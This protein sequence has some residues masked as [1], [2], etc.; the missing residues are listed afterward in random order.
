MKLFRKFSSAVLL[1][2]GFLLGLMFHTAGASATLLFTYTSKDLLWKESYNQGSPEDTGNDIS[3]SFTLT[4]TAPY[5][6]WTQKKSTNFYM[7]NASITV[8]EN[9]ILNQIDIGSLSSGRVTLDQQGNVVG[10]N[11]IL[12]LKEFLAAD[13]SGL[14]KYLH[15]LAADNIDIVSR[16]GAN[17][18]NCD[19]LKKKFHPLY[20]FPR[21]NTYMRLAKQERYY[22][23]ENSAGQW[24]VS[25][26]HVP[27]P[28][29]TTLFLFGLAGLAATRLR[30]KS[31]F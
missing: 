18:C 9:Y 23:Y 28:A 16:Y 3:P 4:F 6:D 15:G 7:Q 21:S 31:P 10:W 29:T 30:K 17:T 13:A 1:K 20:Y 24:Q 22:G 27:E 8:D 11:L 26:I 19:S 5:A 25:R 2:A 12:F 14:E